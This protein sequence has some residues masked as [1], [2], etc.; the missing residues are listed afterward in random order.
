M[1][2]ILSVAALPQ[3]RRKA[4]PFRRNIST[5]GVGSTPES[6]EKLNSKN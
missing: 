6:R 5:V 2:R 4:P 3:H 1:Y